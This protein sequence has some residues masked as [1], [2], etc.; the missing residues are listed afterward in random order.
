MG[1]GAAT[2][3]RR[4]SGNRSVMSGKKHREPGRVDYW[5]DP[6]APAPTSRKPSA[7]VIV[8]NSAGDLLLLRR[9]D[10]GRWTIPTGGLKKNETLTQCAVRECREETGLII[11]VISLVGVFSD[12]RHVSAY[13][14]GKVRQPVNTCFAGRVIGGDLTTTDEASEVAWVA[15]GKLD[16]YD[17]HPSIL[18]RI[19][20][21][22]PRGRRTWTKRG[23]RSAG[24]LPAC[25]AGCSSRPAAGR[26]VVSAWAARPRCS[27]VA[28]PP[29]DLDLDLDVDFAVGLAACLRFAAVP[30]TRSRRRRFPQH[31]AVRRIIEPVPSA[32]GRSLV[33]TAGSGSRPDPAHVVHALR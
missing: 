6:A 18:R 16:G 25:A 30:D 20:R 9:P 12:P 31:L 3:G 8:R 5:D 23:L 11:E 27:V 22:L 7:S 1:I 4:G 24:T 2:S 28:R 29:R 26:A 17:I 10:T 14:D 19:V 13:P 33:T 15:P 21:G 32:D